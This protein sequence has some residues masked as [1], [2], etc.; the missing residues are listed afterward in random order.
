MK[1]GLEG[2]LQLMQILDLLGMYFDVMVVEVKKCLLFFSMALAILCCLSICTMNYWNRFIASFYSKF[3]IKC[4]HVM[5]RVARSSVLS[6]L[7]SFSIQHQLTFSNVSW[8][9]IENDQ[10]FERTEDRT[11][12]IITW[13]H[14]THN[15]EISNWGHSQIVLPKFW[16][17][18]TNQV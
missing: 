6:I 13:T 8:Y 9:Y 3:T 10:K 1:W 5:I 17:F 16:L 18:L 2:G 4:V 14:F 15:L 7:W 12:G 11:T